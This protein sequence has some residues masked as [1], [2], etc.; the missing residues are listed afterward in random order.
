MRYRCAVLD[1]YQNVA[2]RTADWSGVTKDVD[3]TVFNTGL[4]GPDAVARALQGC[5]IVCLMRERTP[6]PANLL[7]RLP[8]LRLLVTTGRRNAA[9][10][11]RAARGQGGHGADA[12]A[13]PRP[14]RDDR[15]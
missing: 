8:R 13:A 11:V 9:I 12:P 6:F 1:D 7:R 15:R 14:C 10:D 5:D 4:G 2:L 3:V